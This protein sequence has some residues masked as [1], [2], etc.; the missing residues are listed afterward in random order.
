[1]TAP[2]DP[3]VRCNLTST[4]PPVWAMEYAAAERAIDPGEPEVPAP[5]IVTLAVWGVAR[6]APPVAADSVSEKVLLPENA[7]AELIFTENDLVVASPL[8]HL[9]VPELAV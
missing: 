2:V 9:S 5:R 4:E 8:L 7:V 1:M 3:P 6:V